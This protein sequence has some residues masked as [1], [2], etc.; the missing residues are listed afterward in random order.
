MEDRSNEDLSK[1]LEAVQQITTTYASSVPKPEDI[2]KITEAY[3]RL[4]SNTQTAAGVSKV[5]EAYVISGIDVVKS[6][7]PVPSQEETAQMRE[8]AV[9]LVPEEELQAVGRV[10]SPEAEELLRA[11][12]N[13]LQ[14]SSAVSFQKAGEPAADALLALQHAL[15]GKNTSAQTA[16]ESSV[17]SEDRPRSIWKAIY[18]ALG[19]LIVVCLILT[20][21]VPEFRDALQKLLQ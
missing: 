9:C 19:V 17:H 18:V 13:A 4:Y 10:T 12:V 14:A 21:V 15:E 6:V 11:V 5:H 2:A 7:F 16:I 3:A 20:L 1:V 8:A